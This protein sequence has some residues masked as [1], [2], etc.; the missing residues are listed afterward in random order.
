MSHRHRSAFTLVDLTVYLVLTCVLAAIGM[1]RYAGALRNFRAA[2]AAN[3]VAADL[4]LAQWTAKSTSAAAGTTVS[5]D[6]TN[7]AYAIPGVPGTTGPASAYAV[8]LSAT[9]YNATLVSATFGGAA[10]VTFD[11]YGQPSSGGNVV[12][13]VGVVQK[14]VTLD[15]GSGK[16]SIQ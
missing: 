16:A 1:P 12:I 10:S 8:A 14:T 3:R 7:S 15:A 6:V 9:P 2:Q 11:R 5:F 4:A 13:A